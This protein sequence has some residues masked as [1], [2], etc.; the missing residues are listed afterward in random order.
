MSSIRS[1]VMCTRLSNFQHHYSNETDQ[2]AVVDLSSLFACYAMPCYTMPTLVSGIP[3]YY[4][5]MIYWRTI[6]PR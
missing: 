1:R 3:N 4:K 2:D 6:T 5:C